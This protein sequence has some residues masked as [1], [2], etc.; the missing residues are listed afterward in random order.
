MPPV[1]PLVDFVLHA[2][3]A[4]MMCHWCGDGEAVRAVAVV[5]QITL[6]QDAH[7]AC[8]IEALAPATASDSAPGPHSR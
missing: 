8:D 6:F 4:S 5:E 2:D 3:G 1:P 7:F